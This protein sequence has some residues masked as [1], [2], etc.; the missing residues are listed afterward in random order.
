MIRFALLSLFSFCCFFLNSCKKDKNECV[1]ARFIDS[2]C[3]KMG[4]VLVILESHSGS[5]KTIAL[6][7]V[8]K[9]FHVRDKIFYVTYHYDETLDIADP[10]ACPLLYGPVKIFVSDSASQNQCSD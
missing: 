6:L 1:K 3:P 5:T 8:P 2:Y 9:E 10:I 4:A 7:N